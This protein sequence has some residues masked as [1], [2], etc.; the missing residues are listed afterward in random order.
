MYRNLLLTVHLA[1]MAAWL[2]CNFTQLFLTPSFARRGGDAAVAWFEAGARLARRYYNV[3]GVGLGVTGVLMVH[4]GGFSWSSGFIWVGVAALVIGA[5][6]GI[7]HFAPE[8]DRLA[9]AQASGDAETVQRSLRRYTAGAV[10]D[11]SI[12]LLTVL[13]MVAKWRS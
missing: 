1:S 3:A 10:L 2:G 12:V 9:A 4:H 6:L 11:T 13:S 5:A 8:G 7:A